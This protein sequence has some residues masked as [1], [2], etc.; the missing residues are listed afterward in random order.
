MKTHKT[1]EIA[2]VKRVTLWDRKFRSGIQNV[3]SSTTFTPQSNALN[4]ALS[5]AQVAIVNSNLPAAG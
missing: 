2:V 5:D 3:P 4:N 1:Y